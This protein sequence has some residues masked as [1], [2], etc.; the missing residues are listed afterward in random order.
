MDLV[1]RHMDVLVLLVA[2]ADGD[3]LVLRVADGDDRPADDVLQLAV[4]E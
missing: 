2:V 3:E 4:R 1:H